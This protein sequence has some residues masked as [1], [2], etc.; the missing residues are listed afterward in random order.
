MYSASKKNY[1]ESVITCV[2]YIHPDIF[3]I[4]AFILLHR[5]DE[6]RTAFARLGEVRSLIPPSVGVMALT[7]TATR[8]LRREVVKT[9]GMIDPVVVTISPDKPNIIFTVASC[10]S[11]EDASCSTPYFSQVCFWVIRWAIVENKM[12]IGRV[13]TCTFIL[14]LTVY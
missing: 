1:S 10:T 8:S 5:G 6:F 4:H 13:Y 14:T 2:G 9:L 7:A 12:Y 11:M 3:I